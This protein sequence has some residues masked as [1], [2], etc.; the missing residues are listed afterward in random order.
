MSFAL[1]SNWIR[2][3]IDIA[4]NLM[5]ALPIFRLE[6]VLGNFVRSDVIGVLQIGWVMKPGTQDTGSIL[7]TDLNVSFVRNLTSRP[8]ATVLA[9]WDVDRTRRIY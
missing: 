3:A 1:T 2:S 7:D 6:V 5:T 4:F 9:S 8:D